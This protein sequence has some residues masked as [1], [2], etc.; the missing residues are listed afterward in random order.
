M[1]AWLDESGAA[2]QNLLTVS[3]LE[4]TL[5]DP[6]GAEAG[7]VWSSQGVC[8]A[9]LLCFGTASGRC[10]FAYADLTGA[11]CMTFRASSFAYTSYAL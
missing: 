11:L 10:V 2:K 3:G 1:A 7:Q 5:G 6:R 4:A 9:D 8:I